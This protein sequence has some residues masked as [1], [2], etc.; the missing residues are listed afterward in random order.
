[1]AGEAQFYLLISAIF[2]F[3]IFIDE[4]YDEFTFADYSDNIF[5]PSRLLK[6]GAT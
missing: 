3:R 5:G 2:H 1:M 4:S 6:Y